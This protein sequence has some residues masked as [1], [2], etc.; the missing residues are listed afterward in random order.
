[1]EEHDDG[2]GCSG[3]GGGGDK[4]AE[5]EIAGWVD[6]DVGGGDA[7]DGFGIGRE[8]AVDYVEEGAVDGAIGAARGV[9]ESGE[10]EDG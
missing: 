9:T 6:G 10:E 3:R 5:P 1:M 8:L 7:V 2:K 4:E